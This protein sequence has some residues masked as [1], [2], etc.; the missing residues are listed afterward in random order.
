MAQRIPWAIEGAYDDIP[1]LR[2]LA[3]EGYDRSQ[4]A[5]IL[6]E[7]TGR[8]RTADAVRMI[9]YRY[10][11]R[12]VD[13][14]RLPL[15]TRVVDERPERTI[16]A[17]QATG[18]PENAEVW[19]QA[20]RRTARDLARA[21]QE[22]YAVVRIASDKPICISLSSDWHLSPRGPVDL[23]GLRTYAEAIR[24]TPGAFAVCVG[25]LHQNPVRHEISIPDVADEIKLVDYAL[26]IFGMK[27]LAVV[28]GNHDYRTYQQSGLDHLRWLADRKK[29]HYAPDELSLILEIVDPRNTDEVTARYHIALR[30]QYRR[31]SFLNPLHACWRYLEERVGEWPL[32][33]DGGE[34]IPDVI[35]IGHHHV[36]AVGSESRPNKRIWAAR[37]GAWQWESGYS[38]AKGFRH[39][40]PTAP[41]FVFWPHRE[42][43]PW[44][45]EYY[46]EALTMLRMWRQQAA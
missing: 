28:G 22:R 31:H 35:A 16:L 24:D 27:M 11:I 12:T 43:E 14:Y 40:T 2:E 17:S 37:F 20:E 9:C 26:G 18:E 38:R 8:T 25:D 46:E 21:Q 1:M 3:N 15:I 41:S 19:Q 36:A 7:R 4:I 6:T 32:G 45:S 29:V 13:S 42:R 34:M 33:L 5:R 30:H 23:G 39:S 44:G 10:G